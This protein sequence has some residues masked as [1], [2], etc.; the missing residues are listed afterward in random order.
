MQSVQD[1]ELQLSGRNP[2]ALVKSIGIPPRPAV[3]LDNFSSGMAWS[4]VHVAAL[5]SR[6]GHHQR[7]PY[8]NMPCP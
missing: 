8:L 2:I 7:T 6:G 3:L 4:S 1:V 5:P